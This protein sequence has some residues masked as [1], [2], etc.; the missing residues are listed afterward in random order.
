[1]TDY[2]YIVVGAGAAGSVLAARLSETP[3]TSVLLIEAGEENPDDIGRSQGAFLL[4]WDS[5][6]NWNYETTPQT[7]LG[8]R[9]IA[10][11]RGKAVGGSTTINVGA[12][13]R[14]R[15]ED[16]DAWQAAGADGWNAKAALDVYTRVEATDR[17][18][19][20]LRGSAGPLRMTDLPSP[21]PLA[22]TLLEAYVKAGL[23]SP[24]DSNGADP[25]VAD[26]FQTLF[27][28]GV[29]R[30]VADAYLTT[31]VRQRPNFTLLTSAYVNRVLIDNGHATG[32]EITTGEGTSTVRARRE[33]VLSAGTYNTPQILMLSGV[34]PRAHLEELGIDVVADVPAVGQGLRDH[35]YAHVY[36]LAKAGVD[37]SVPPDLSDEAIRSWLDTHSG[38]A[39]YFA[40]NGVA[41]A[42]VEQSATV[43]DFELL[44]S[45]NSGNANFANIPDAVD[46]S[47]V[48]IGVVLSQ[49]R[50][51]GSVR[52][53]STDPTAKPLIDHAYLTDPADVAM[54]VAG[55]RIA[56][57]IV[58]AEPLQPYSEDVYP[59]VDAS[60]DE[61]AD[62]VR[63]DAATVYHPV[64][65]AR[66][67]NPDDPAVVVDA[68]L[69]VKGVRGLRVADASVMPNLI[70]GHT[71]AP[72]VFIGYRAADLLSS[73][74]QEHHA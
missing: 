29:R 41:W 38:P 69:R 18:P 25:F 6:K 63:A 59:A 34:G 4:T 68:D 14:G 67:G 2:D 23:G 20:E 26:R 71:M 61:L 45:Y 56:H 40:E 17:G 50:S 8:G 32:V 66:M 12:W 70:H 3:Q 58:A 22:E 72:A 42:A 35:L 65:T 21:T 54:L 43:P 60:D 46:R 49:P 73:H 31:D 52:L 74:M 5:A 1:M 57:R 24:G 51:V 16:Y 27:V 9:V 15:P 48:S 62:F 36:T 11:P 53:T 28:D 37:G 7:G 44:L 47:G 30:D 13:L 19:A 33:V 55:L 39:S 64:G 10:H